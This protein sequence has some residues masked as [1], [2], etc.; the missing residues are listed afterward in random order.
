VIPGF[1][2]SSFSWPTPFEPESHKPPTDLSDSAEV[3]AGEVAHY[4]GPDF[5]GEVGAFLIGSKPPRI[6]VLQLLL[7]H[8]GTLTKRDATR[9]FR[10]KPTIKINE[11]A[12]APASAACVSGQSVPASA[13]SCLGL[14]V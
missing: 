10:L 1:N 8:D 6:S 12:L 11:V 4:E 5:V 2:I 3:L 13:V 9:S 7:L 14:E